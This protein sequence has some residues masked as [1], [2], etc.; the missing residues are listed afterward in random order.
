MAVKFIL[1]KTQRKEEE[2]ITEILETIRTKPRIDEPTK[3]LATF[4]EVIFRTA[5]QRNG[6]Y[7]QTPAAN[8]KPQLLQQAPIE[9]EKKEYLVRLFDTPVGIIVDKE[10]GRYIYRVMEPKADTS[11][12]QKTKA[13]I[14]RDFERS[15]MVLEDRRYMLGQIT[16]ACKKLKTHCDADVERRATYYLKRDILGFRR[17][18][19]LMH[20]MNVRGIFVDGTDKPVRIEYQG[21]PEKM[22]T[23]ITFTDPKDLN[24]LINRV[25]AL[26][27]EKLSSATPVIDVTINGF[28]IHATIGIGGVSSKLTIRKLD[29]P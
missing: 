17:L 20:D 16:N 8:H 28:D 25:A 5:R 29:L 14:K 15:H 1:D 27:G 13:L 12:I 2:L 18:D 7:A 6:A 11:I 24:T 3:K 10:D 9:L 23:N 19:P 21:I 26:T 22:E 4:I